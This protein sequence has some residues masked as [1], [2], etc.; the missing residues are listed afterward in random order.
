MSFI[1]RLF[2]I[3][4]LFF[5]GF[6]AFLPGVVIHGSFMPHALVCAFLFVVA[7]WILGLLLVVFMVGT[8]GIGAILII[9]GQALLPVLQLQLMAHVFPSYVIVSGWEAATV[10]GLCIFVMQWTLTRILAKR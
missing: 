3:A 1:I 7:G 8:L 5:Y 9:L 10:G 4:A 2:A 6:P